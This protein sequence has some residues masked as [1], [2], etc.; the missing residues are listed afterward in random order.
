[1]SLSDALP[2]FRRAIAAL[3]AMLS[4]LAGESPAQAAQSPVQAAQSV[5][6][7]AGLTR[8][9]ARLASDELPTGAGVVVGQVEA[10][11][12]GA[13]VLDRAD[14]EFRGK[15]IA[16]K[17]GLSRGPSTHA[18]LVAQYL[19]GLHSSL[20]PGIERVDAF[21]AN[22][23]LGAGLLGGSGA[24]LP[25]LVDAKVFCNSWIGEAGEAS[26]AYLRK[27]DFAIETQGLIVCAGVNNGRGPLDVALLSHGFNTLTVGR[28]DGSHRA[29]TTSLG[30]DG[31]GRMKPDLVAPAGATSFSTP[32]VSGAAALLV[33]TARSLP[34][35]A[36]HPAAESPDVIKAVLLAG[37]AH[38]PGWSNSPLARGA[39]RG[40]TSMPLDP[41]LGAGQ[42]DVEASHWILSAGEQWAGATPALA[43][44]CLPSG[45][46]WIEIGPGQSRWLRFHVESLRTEVS[47]VAAW[48]RAVASD[49]QSW[50]LAD[51]DLELWTADA[52]GGPSSLL[53]TAPGEFFE[54]GNVLSDSAVDNVEHLY[55]QRL[56]PGEYLLEVR[57]SS[58]DQ[59]PARAA[60][61]WRFESVAPQVFGEA[62]PSSSG[63]LPALRW[64]GRPSR[65]GDDF[66]LTVSRAEPGS[67]GILLCSAGRGE[68]PFAGGRLALAP[69]LTRFAV[70]RADDSGSATI[71]IPISPERVGTK[72]H[73]QFWF[74]DPGQADGSGSGLTNALEVRFAP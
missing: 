14:R 60:L 30:V 24:A 71:P 39:S 41:V 43:P 55:V 56:L 11:A 64:T 18:T 68:L 23:W 36:G 66:E 28:S 27:L 20:S 25:T 32:L 63:K 37:A 12:G 42:L 74:R 46:A 15:A 9:A 1:M 50:S 49:F 35:L 21:E 31:P 33:E 45:W 70:A 58:D 4:A 69:P 8:L 3:A 73:F 29:G 44:E 10:P 7:A 57:R 72:L 61:A 52:Q 16:N 40:A 19:V 54:T 51:L 38:L 53:G 5:Q 17:S 22:H 13:F 26:N 2:R 6:E 47:I 34:G 48:N 67:L 59:G 62:K 65:H